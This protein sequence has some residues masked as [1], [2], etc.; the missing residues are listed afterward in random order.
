MGVCN[1]LMDGTLNSI[2][3][4]KNQSSKIYKEIYVLFKIFRINIK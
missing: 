3:T 4:T 2:H 1:I